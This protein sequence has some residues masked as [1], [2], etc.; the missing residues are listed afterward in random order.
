MF[1]AFCDKLFAALIDLLHQNMKIS[2][3]KVIIIYFK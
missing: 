1:L 3:F 2:K